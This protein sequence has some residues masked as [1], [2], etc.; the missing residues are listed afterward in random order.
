MRRIHPVAELFP[1]M[2][3]SQF[4]CLVDDIRANGLREPILVHQEGS[5]IDGRNRYRACVVLGIEPSFRTWDGVGSLVSLVMSLNLHRRHLD[6][7]QRAMVGA[8][9]LPLFE[10]EARL[11]QMSSL[12]QNMPI[13][14]GSTVRANW[15][16]RGKA[17]EKA[18]VAVGVSPRSVERAAVIVERGA[19]DLIAAVDQGEVSVSAASK[20]T[21]LPQEDQA[22][23]VRAGDLNF[24]LFTSLERRIELI[25]ADLKQ[26]FRNISDPR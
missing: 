3:R 24:R 18:A 8:R 7:S 23:I 25:E 14:A 17:S 16:E 22:D 4:D 21:D 20:L 15:Q 10:E 13:G 6:E 5:V 19:P 9:S 2:S 1:E 26:F 12:K 11:R